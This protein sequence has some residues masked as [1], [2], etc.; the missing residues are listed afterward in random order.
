MD[1]QS[2]GQ[3]VAK[4]LSLVGALLTGDE[5][6]V[7]ECGE[8]QVTGITRDAWPGSPVMV[9]LAGEFGERIT[10]LDHVEFTG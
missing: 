4:V 7:K 9:I 3:Y 8:V 5:I 6:T 10:P 2:T 1:S